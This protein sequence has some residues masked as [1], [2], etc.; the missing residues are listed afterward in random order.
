MCIE[1]PVWNVKEAANQLYVILLFVIDKLFFAVVKM[2]DYVQDA[3][4]SLLGDITING[5]YLMVKK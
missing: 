1:T 5:K 3:K 2:S 4:G